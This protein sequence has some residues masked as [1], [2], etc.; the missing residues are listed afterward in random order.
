M[1]K[2]HHNGAELI[3]LLEYGSTLTVMRIETFDLF[4][5]SVKS[6]FYCEPNLSHRG[7]H[8]QVVSHCRCLLF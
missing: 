8:R 1:Q 4:D 7:N 5:F 3:I 6:F 2:G